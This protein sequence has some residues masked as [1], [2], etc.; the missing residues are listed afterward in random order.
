MEEEDRSDVGSDDNIASQTVVQNLELLITTLQSHFRFEIAIVCDDIGKQS[1]AVKILLSATKETAREMKDLKVLV[2]TMSERIDK[3]TEENR[4]L[5]KQTPVPAT[6][7]LPPPPSTPPPRPKQKWTGPQTPHQPAKQLR[8]TSPT[9]TLTHSEHADVETDPAQPSPSTSA[10]AAG[11][12]PLHG[13]TDEGWKKVERKRNGKGEKRGAVFGREVGVPSWAGKARGRGGFSVTVF[14]GG[15]KD[16]RPQKARKPKKGRSRA[17]RLRDKGEVGKGA[18]VSARRERSVG[19]YGSIKGEDCELIVLQYY[20]GTRSL[21]IQ[22]GRQ[23]KG[24][25]TAPPRA[26][27]RGLSHVRT[28][29]HLRTPPHLSC[30]GASSSPDATLF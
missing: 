18:G 7:P 26:G 25:K 5:R 30:P 16:A 21:Y 24:R 14:I 19:I 27:A 3:L 6:Q 8:D 20:A 23:D 9:P 4:A 2:T 29:L 12:A 11:P 13:N 22:E 17:L 10:T 28:P 15:N 1:A